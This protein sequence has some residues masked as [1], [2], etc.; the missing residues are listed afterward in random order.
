MRCCWFVEEN[1]VYYALL[2]AVHHNHH[3]HRMDIDSGS[4]SDSDSDRRVVV[5]KHHRPV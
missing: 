4:D 5:S 2:V 1:D 3:H